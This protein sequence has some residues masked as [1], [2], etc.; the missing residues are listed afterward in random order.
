MAQKTEIAELLP[1]LIIGLGVLLV[2]SE[3]YA[4]SVIEAIQ[5][6]FNKLFRL[7]ILIEPETV[8]LFEHRH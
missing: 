7:K 2:F 4:C 6:E 1:L 5:I 3:I 8:S